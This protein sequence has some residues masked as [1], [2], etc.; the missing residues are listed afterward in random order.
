M[1]IIG[2][3]MALCFATCGI[4]L[5]WNAVRKGNA[6]G[7]SRAF[8]WLW[9]SGLILGVFYATFLKSWPLLGNYSANIVQAAIVLKY[10]YFPTKRNQNEEW[11][12]KVGDSSLLRTRS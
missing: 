6:E 5:A 10:S 11:N 7:V 9:V 3:T 4:P 12:T 1:E 8:L 2:W